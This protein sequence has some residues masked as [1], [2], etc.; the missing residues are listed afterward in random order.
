MLNRFAAPLA[1]ACALGACQTERPVGFAATPPAAPVPQAA[2]APSN[3]AIFQHA[4]GY[5]PLHYGQR[6]RRLG[7]PITVVLAERTT[8][9]KTAAGTTSRNGSVSV[10]PPSAGPLAI[11]P[12][13]LSIGAKG[14]FNG[15]GDAAQSSTLAGEITVTI[16]EILPNNTVRIRGEKLMNFSQGQEWVQ[17]SGIIRLADI[18]A[19]NRVFSPRIADAQIAYGGKGSIQRAGREGWLS[20]F[21]SQI[22]P[23]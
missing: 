22:S 2:A 6:A 5:A 9:A 15:K 19:D 10:T 4:A 7:D 1:L 23:F 13:I 3:G 14:N 11:D 16:A 20:R 17:L 12:G 8:T 21:F 18:D